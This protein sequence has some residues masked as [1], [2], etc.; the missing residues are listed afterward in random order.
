MVLDVAVELAVSVNVG[1][2]WPLNI[3]AH[4]TGLSGAQPAPCHGAPHPGLARRDGHGLTEV[5]LGWLS[6]TAQDILVGVLYSLELCRL[7]NTALSVLVERPACRAGRDG[8]QSD[9]RYSA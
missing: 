5:T 1:F 9:A 7:P 2:G 3:C 4:Y 8:S 6:G